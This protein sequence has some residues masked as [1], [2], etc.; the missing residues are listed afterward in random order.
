VGV[1]CYHRVRNFKSPVRVVAAILL[2]SRETQAK[3]ARQRTQKIQNLKTI[4]RQQDRILREKDEQRTAQRRRIAELEAENETL[5]KQPLQFP[6]DPPLRCHKFGPITIA[7]CVNLVR[8]VGF[9]AAPDVLEIVFDALG[10]EGKTLP[11]WTTVRTWV[12]RVGVA[13]IDRPIEPS[14]DWI[15]MADHSNQIGPEKAL[16]IIGLQASNLPSPGRPLRHE[17]VRVLDLAVGTSWKRE[18]MTEAY[19]QLAARSGGAPLALVVDGAVE[20]REG[21]E[22]CEFSRDNGENTMILR[23]FKHYAANVMKKVVGDDE[24]FRKFGTE[25]GRTRSAIQQTELA[26]FTP[27][28][29]KPKARFMNLACTLQWAAM[30]LW[31]LSHFRSE[32][33]HGIAAKRMNEKLGWLREYRDDVRSWN[34]CQNVVSA[35]LTFLNGQGVFRGAARGLGAHVRARLRGVRNKDE[36]NA[37][38]RQ[39]LA[40]LLKFVRETESQLSEGQRLPMSTEILE[41]SFGLFKRLERQHSKG[42]FTSLLAAYGGLFHRSTPETIRRDFAQV[43]VRRMRAW[44]ERNLGKTLNSK[45][46]IAYRE[47]R[48]AN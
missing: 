4:L 3:R 48:N 47:F 14:D 9:R 45:R 18:D 28:G 29:L 15:W 23:D 34:A 32:S 46:Q 30:V 1:S 41:S 24:R 5:R 27:S 2:R 13:A 19:E 44:V 8:R 31:H 6:D 16:S 25:L 22:M 10:I 21:A 11:D 37:A 26:H 36:G 12:L 39:V 35:A 17:D 20:L 40:R 43:S 38:S 42:G 7:M 33:R